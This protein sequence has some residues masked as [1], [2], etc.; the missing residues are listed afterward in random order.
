MKLR[1]LLLW[2][3]GL[4]LV[5]VAATAV[6]L[7][8]IDADNLRNSELEQASQDVARTLAALQSL[9]LEFTQFKG[10]RV[11]RQWTLRSQELLQTLDHARSLDDASPHLQTMV[12]EAQALNELFAELNRVVPGEDADVEKRRHGL[13]LERLLSTSEGLFDSRRAWAAELTGRMDSVDRRLSFALLGLPLLFLGALAA[14]TAIIWSSVLRPLQHLE[15]TARRVEQGD[16]SAR[17]GLHSD[18]EVGQV[19][20]AID[21][22]TDALLQAQER[23]QLL[24]SNAPLGIFIRDMERRLVLANPAWYHI[25]GLPDGKG[26]D[27]PIADVVHPDDLHIVLKHVKA[28]L[29]TGQGQQWEV[30]YLHPDGHIVWVHTHLTPML[31]NGEWLGVFGLVEN[32]TPQRDLM[33]QLARSNQDL[34]SFAYVASHDLQE[35]L[36]MVNSYGQLLSRRYGESLE[37]KAR[38]FLAHMVDGGERAQQLIRALLDL[39]RVNSQARPHLPVDLGRVLN[40]VLRRQQAVLTAAGATLTHDELP[41]AVPG[42]ER[43]LLQLL[44]NLVLNAVKYRSEAAPLIHVGARREAEVWHLVVRDNG[45]GIAPQFFD[46]VFVMFQRLHL[47]SERPGTGIGLAICKR[48]VERHGG[49]IWV[50]ST[51]GLGSEFHFTLA[52]GAVDVPQRVPAWTPAALAVAAHDAEAGDA[53]TQNKARADGLSWEI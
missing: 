23:L 44:E 30:R 34:E 14:C 21:H 5:V 27:V 19:A 40:E 26:E 11:V 29:D 50:E 45:I 31:R 9:T 41:P 51:P 12:N 52:A 24:M 4:A 16:V 15:R 2:T 38:E 7:A 22:M 53:V 48:V 18:N 1:S 35:P 28:L 13:L 25:A 33:A 46:K 49:R 8:K 17:A 10:P 32:I 43:Q 6:W 42:D 39:A 37:P 3:F 20:A 47:R 36:R